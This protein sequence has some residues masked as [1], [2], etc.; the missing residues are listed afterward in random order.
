MITNILPALGGIRLGLLVW[1]VAGPV[2]SGGLVYGSMR[3]REAIVVSGAVRAARDGATVVCNQ[4]VAEIQRVHDRE[5]DDSVD[6]VIAAIDGLG[7]APVVMADRLARCK[8]S[9]GCLRREGTP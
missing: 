7:P 8:A 4:R 6:D 5:V 2:L 9:P 3:V 1:A